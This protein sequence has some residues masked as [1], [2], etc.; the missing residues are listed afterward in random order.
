MRR[1]ILAAIMAVIMTAACAVPAMAASHQNALD[2]MY[3]DWVEVPKSYLTVD[4]ATLLKDAQSGDLKKLAADFDVKVVDITQPTPAMAAE[5]PAKTGTLTQDQRRENRYIPELSKM[6]FNDVTNKESIGL[7]PILMTY[8]TD[9]TLRVWTIVLNKTEKDVNV[10]GLDAVQILDDQ[11]K[12]FAG[13]QNAKFSTP[14]K[15]PNNDTPWFIILV[16]HPGTFNPNE[17]LKDLKN[18]TIQYTFME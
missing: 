9:G 18:P 7:K 8:E 6:N 11:K 17:S 1:K 15:L 13:G 12:V 10:K 14:L 16:F 4:Y 5:N 3:H 2:E